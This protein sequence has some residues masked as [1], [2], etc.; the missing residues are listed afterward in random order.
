MRPSHGRAIDPSPD[1]NDDSLD[2][3]IARLRRGDPEALDELLKTYWHPLV[4]YADRLMRGN[5]DLAEDLVQEA[6]IRLWERR[7]T[8]DE[9]SRAAPILYTIVRNLASNKRRNAATR[10]LLLRLFP[11]PTTERRTAEHALEERE[12]EDAVDRAV[13][14]LPPRRRE[15]FVLARAHG[16][17]YAEIATVM[18][19]STRTVAN[20]MVSALSTLRKALRPF[21]REPRQEP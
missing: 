14:A 2:D 5:T 3:A 20:Q 11:P 8:W 7:A 10:S 18:S 4:T 17:S 13:D 19:I 6:F 12:M 21:L 15:I 9:S 16:L 1:R